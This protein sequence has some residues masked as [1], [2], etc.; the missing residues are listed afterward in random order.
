MNKIKLSILDFGYRTYTSFQNNVSEIIDYSILLDSLGFDR[1]W[2]SEHHNS[3]GIQTYLDPFNLIC[4]IAA[5]TD[6]IT[7][8][9]GG[10]LIGYH[11]VYD[12]A[13]NYKFMSNLFPNRIDLG[14]AKGKPGNYNSHNYFNI[15]DELDHSTKVTKNILQ[16]IDFYQKE[17]YYYKEQNILFPPYNGLTPNL[18]YYSNSYKNLNFCMENKLNF[19][20]SLIHG[21]N[22]MQSDSLLDDLLLYK[23]EYYKVN[24]MEAE[25]AIAVAV[26]FSFTLKEINRYNDYN[27]NN[28]EIF[29]INA[30]DEKTFRA[31]IENLT[32]KFGIYDIIIFDTE[33]NHEKRM[34]NA[35]IMSDLIVG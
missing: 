31:F 26:S 25:V 8:G 20:R 9:S 1:I 2:F 10:S 16:L 29:T 14:L 34:E 22:M 21:K 18:W 35:K 24:N 19:C 3:L 30:V 13:S 4:L 5:S 23:N 32:M 15:D 33:T 17:E 27:K 6:T 11:S 12:I 7:V 28:P